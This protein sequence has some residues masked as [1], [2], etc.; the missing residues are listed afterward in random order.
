MARLSN[1]LLLD[2]CETIR[3]ILKVYLMGQVET[4][5]ETADAETALQLLELEAFDLVIAD[6]RMEPIDGVAFVR[7]VRSSASARVRGTPVVLLT[8]DLSLQL[9]AEGLGAGANAFVH[10]PITAKELRDTLDMVAARA[11]G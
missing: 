1:I 10:K 3:T 6:V 5:R 9:R 8:S 4:F 7:Q 2:D 11:T